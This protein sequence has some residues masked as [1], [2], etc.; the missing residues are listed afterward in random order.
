M[1]L[2]PL[3]NSHVRPD[4]IGEESPFYRGKNPLVRPDCVGEE[5]PFYRGVQPARTTRLYRGRKLTLSRVQGAVNAINA[6]VVG[7]LAAT[8][9][10]PIL[11]AS[12]TGIWQAI[13]VL[14]AFAWLRAKQPAIWQVVTVF[15]VG[16]M[17][18]ALF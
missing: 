16:G 5:S 18:S 4:C 2:H 13:I 15:V 3:H 8:L 10:F 14:L 11:P 17:V 7:L 6:A 9:I 1:T 12:V